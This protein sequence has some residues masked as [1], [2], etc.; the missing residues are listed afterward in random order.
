MLKILSDFCRVHLAQSNR[1]A[2]A[3]TLTRGQSA[4]KNKHPVVRLNER[5]N[6]RKFFFHLRRTIATAEYR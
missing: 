3:V 4:N 2:A 6:R 5:S 1:T